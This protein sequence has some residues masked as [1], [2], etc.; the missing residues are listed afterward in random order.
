MDWRVDGLMD[1]QADGRMDRQMACLHRRESLEAILLLNDDLLFLNDD[2]N[3]IHY[4][5]E[6]QEYG[7]PIYVGGKSPRD[8]IA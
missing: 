7:W 8:I 6:K 4:F 5:W 1:G 3:A 2:Y